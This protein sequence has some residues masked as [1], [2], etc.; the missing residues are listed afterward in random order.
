MTVTVTSPNVFVPPTLVDE[1]P[2]SLPNMVVESAMPVS[3]AGLAADVAAQILLDVQ[4]VALPA[5]DFM[6]V[7]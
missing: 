1:Q 4:P 6:V 7:I 2:V 5:S 3:I